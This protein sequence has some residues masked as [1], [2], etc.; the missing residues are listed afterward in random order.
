MILNKEQVTA[1]DFFDK[2]I[3]YAQRFLQSYPGIQLKVEE[4]FPGNKQESHGYC[5]DSAIHCTTYEISSP[6]ISGESGTERTR[7]DA[8]SE[9]GQHPSV[10]PR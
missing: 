6:V 9:F 4:N 5:R 2:L 10:Y 1:Q 7:L 3:D 8:F